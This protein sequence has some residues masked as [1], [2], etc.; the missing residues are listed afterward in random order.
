MEERVPL[1]RQKERR[2]M[3]WPDCVAI[4][5]VLFGSIVGP[6]AGGD[7]SP[8]TEAFTFVQVSDPQLGWGYGY[9]NDMESFRQAVSHINGLQPDF[10]VICGDMVDS[11][12]DTSVADF[13]QARS[14]LTVPSYCAPGN[15][16]VGN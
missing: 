9:A 13:Q 2:T 12:N 1:G 11:F 10:V 15:H 16:D 14:E 3:K 7:Q 8:A 4:S 5:L 6:A